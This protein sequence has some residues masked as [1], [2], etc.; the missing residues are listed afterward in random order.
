M[1]TVV[2][3]IFRMLVPRSVI[4]LF[5]ATSCS[6]AW[7]CYL[8]LCVYLYANSFI[9]P[10]PPMSYQSLT[11]CWSYMNAL[12][13]QSWQSLN[14]FNWRVSSFSCSYTNVHLFRCQL[15]ITFPPCVLSLHMQHVFEIHISLNIVFFIII[16]C[17]F[18]FLLLICC[19]MFTM[20]YY[21]TTKKLTKL[22]SSSNK[23][24]CVLHQLCHIWC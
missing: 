11:S 14:A 19:V 1:Q 5:I 7:A 16:S 13:L 22:L 4:M 8:M 15:W 21:Q 23:R 10:T 17:P 9:V 3:V 2:C 24:L 20:C 12:F 18:M 6:T